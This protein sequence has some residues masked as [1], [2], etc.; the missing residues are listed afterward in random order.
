MALSERLSRFLARKG[1]T[2]Q[3]L[4]TE[5]VANLDAAVLAS[6]K[7]QHDFIKATLL[8]D[9]NGVVMVVHR[10]DSTLD[11]DAVHQ[12]TGRRLQP[13]TARQTSR[14]F[15]DCDAGFVPPIGAAWELPVL[16]DEDV[17]TAESVIFSGG[18]DHSLVEMDGRAFRLAQAGA[19]QG[20]LV[21]RGQGVED[22]EA[23]TL[24]D[25][26][27]KLQKLYRLPPMPAL[28]LRIL[29]LTANTEATAKELAELIEFDPSMTAQIMRYARS[30]LFNYPGQINSVQ[31]AVT[32]V[33]GFDRVA[34][35]AL[36][37]ASV[38][39]FD[40]PRGGMLGMDNFWR[41]SLYCA[42]LCQNL[43]AYSGRDKGLAYLCGL[44][45]NFGLLLVGHLFPSEF[46]ELNALREINPE[47]SMHSLEQE[48]FG[49]SERQD[50]LAVGH[51]AIGGILH[52]LWQLPEAVIKAAGMHQHIGY[53]GE[54]EEY[55]QMVQLANAILKERGIG[56]E[57][58]PDDLPAL[59][60]SLGLRADVLERV[61]SDMDQVASDLDV[62]ASSLAS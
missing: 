34:H 45:H 36:G 5:P 46:E 41:H 44:L 22:R 31:E 11:M 56:D 47:A 12:F 21:I 60:E 10:F 8:I 32:R 42:F 48:V 18:T 38:R 35:I 30:A 26:A 17:V 33:L 20:H 3:P 14:L 24:E 57:L 29:R 6:G 59:V 51:G 25:V 54:H 16:V 40:V 15:G 9:I 1:I 13:L 58:N 53:H 27:D 37:I 23:L 43:A 4:E 49:H 55:V 52:R 61:Q 62:L 39:A 19:R 28:A 50:I 7:P 2:Y